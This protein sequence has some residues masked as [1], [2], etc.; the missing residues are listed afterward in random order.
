MAV[1]LATALVAASPASAHRRDELL[2]AA[3]IAIEPGRVELQLDLTPGIDVATAV[4][5]SVDRDRDGVMSA[6]EQRQYTADMLGAVSLDVDGIALRLTPVA[7]TFP[8]IQSFTRGEGTIQLRA[9]VALPPLANG[10]HRLSYRNHSR[11]DLSV[12]LANA[13]GPDDD[14]VAVH[15]QRRDTD[16]RDL[17]IEYELRAEPSR[18]GFEWPLIVVGAACAVMLHGL[19]R[20]RLALP[21]SGRS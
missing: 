6:D 20:R 12:Y 7:S 17:T 14:R 13:L 10:A 18:A 3:R 11:P 19:Y 9:Q 1:T 16:Q 8:D 2:Q 15:L 4:V 5:T 21:A